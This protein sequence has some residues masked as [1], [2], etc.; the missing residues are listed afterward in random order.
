MVQAE[1][2]KEQK[3][4]PSQFMAVGGGVGGRW[5]WAVVLV[6]YNSSIVWGEEL[7]QKQWVWKGKLSLNS[8]ESSIQETPVFRTL[9]A[10][11]LSLALILQAV[12][13]VVKILL[14]YQILDFT[15]LCPNLLIPC[16]TP[17]KC[18]LHE[19]R[20][21]VS[22]MSPKPRTPGLQKK[23]NKYWLNE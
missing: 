14:L 18:Q 13:G 2:Q 8:K 12:E 1:K 21:H 20:D 4:K 15:Y 7:G 22:L 23:L 5:R 17:M 3:R 10:E 9:K 16:S 6:L 19:S 11:C